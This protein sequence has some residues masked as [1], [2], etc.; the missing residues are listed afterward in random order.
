MCVLVERPDEQTLLG[1]P[2]HGCNGNNEMDLEERKWKDADWIDFDKV[3]Q[4][5]RDV[6]EMVMDILVLWNAMNK[7][8]SADWE[9]VGFLIRTLLYRIS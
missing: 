8:I 2:N 5:C 4:K 3:R 9:N 6:V 1:R 7:C